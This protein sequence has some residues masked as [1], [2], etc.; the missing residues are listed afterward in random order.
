MADTDISAA[1]ELLRDSFTRLIEHVD[2]L[3]DGLTDEVAY[4]RADPEPTPS[5]G[6]CGTAPACRTPSSATIAGADQVWFRD[7]WVGRFDLDLPKDSHGYGHTPNRSPRCARRRICS[8]G[9]YHAV[10]SMALEFVASVT[11]ED[12]ETHRRQAV[13]AAGHGERPHRQHHRRLRAAP[14]AGGLRP[15]HRRRRMTPLRRCEWWPPVGLAADGRAR[16]GGG[17]GLDAARRLVHPHRA[18]RIPSWASCCSSPSRGCCSAAPG[19]PSRLALCRRRWRL[20]LVVVADAGGRP[21]VA[22]RLLKRL[23][24]R[25]NARARWPTPAGT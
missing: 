22:V 3:A 4:Y 17:H 2:D 18:P 14:R 16:P 11:A 15:G 5:P 10:H 1:R 7:G 9:Y 13:D 25:E 6:C 24:G 19:A 20:A 23:F 12:L 21:V 8:A